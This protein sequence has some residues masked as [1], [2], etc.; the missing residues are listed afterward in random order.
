MSGEAEA[1]KSDDGG[2]AFPHTVNYRGVSS[3]GHNLYAGMSIRDYF[4]G[5]AIVGLSSGRGF[6]DPRDRQTV[7]SRAYEIADLMLVERNRDRKV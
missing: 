6:I 2:P 3:G 7:V 5:Q 1:N 4:A